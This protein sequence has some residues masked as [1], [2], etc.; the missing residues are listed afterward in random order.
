MN[1]VRLVVTS[2]LALSL[3]LSTWSFAGDGHGKSAIYQLAEIMHRLKHYPSPQG[4]RELQVI[5][6]A[7]ST[8]S[9]ERIIEKAM[10]NVEH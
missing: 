6:Q 10:M 8:T 4:K 7:K 5:V 1:M 2:G 3:F 9:N